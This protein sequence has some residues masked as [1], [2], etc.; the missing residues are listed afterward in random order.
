MGFLSKYKNKYSKSFCLAVFFV[1]C[2]TVCDLML[3]TVMVEII[4]VG[5]ASKD[6]NYILS[7]GGLMVLITILGFASATARNLISS[8]VSQKFGTELRSDLYRKIQHLSFEKIDQLDRASLV[9]R[10]TN[11]VIQVQNFV[12]GLMRI[13][14]K[15]PLLCIGSLLMAIRL[16][17]NL[18]LILA[19]VVPVV[20]VF[21]VVNMK[22][23]YPL[24]SKVQQALDLVNGVMREYLS[25]IR[26]VKAFNRFDYEVNKFNKANT[27]LQ[28][29]SVASMRLMSIFSPGILMSVN[30]GIAAVL[31]FGGVQVNSGDMQSGQVIAFIN[32]MAQMLFSLMLMSMVFNMFVRAKS[33][34]ERIHEVLS[35]DGNMTWEKNRMEDKGIKGRVDFEN[36]YFSYEGT[37][38]S[39]VLKNVTLTC[40]PGE[41]I[42]VIGA[43]GS[44]KS[45]LVHLIP[46]FYDIT[47]GSL[48][49]NGEKISSINPQVIREKIAVVGQKTVLFTGTVIENIRWG[50]E[51]ATL[52][53][54]EI[55]AKIAQ[56]HDFI[57][58]LPEGY[59]TRVGQGGVNFSGG[60]KQRISIARALVRN[61][62]ILILDD[63]T[64]AVDVVTEKKIKESLKRYTA[65]L[66]CF[67]IA[68]RVTSV[69]DADKIVVLDQG[70]IV[71]IGKHDELLQSCA[72]YQ[73]ILKS[74][75]GKVM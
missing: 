34:A 27:E 11:D 20:G 21:I 12:N 54:I 42:G 73:E 57:M 43:T 5:V 41:M 68:Q 71:G 32:Y 65:H 47:S 24:F 23:G 51:D 17:S 53:E 62:E 2:E 14:I 19:V 39:P 37:L 29:R 67:M 59:E 75:V 60:Q 61:P 45:S 44:G 10:L 35:Q 18:A 1:M 4:D 25:G 31:W 69:M 6:M 64:S 8:Q 46:R 26:V 70:E 38:E 36:V 55:A 9:T 22:M 40:M 3:P 28:V 50:K 63:S 13:F 30:T 33:S 72:V 15:A 66:T 52:E 56:V 49:V 74:Q 16:N 7:M 48:K 58:E